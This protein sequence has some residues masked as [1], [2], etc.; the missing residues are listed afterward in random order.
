[1]QSETKIYD[2]LLLCLGHLIE[3]YKTLVYLVFTLGHL[4]GVGLILILRVTELSITTRL[5]QV[6]RLTNYQLTHLIHKPTLTT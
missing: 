6:R 4:F 1:M 5:F 3:A 2:S